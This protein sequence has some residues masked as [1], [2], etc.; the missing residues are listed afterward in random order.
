MYGAQRQ[1]GAIGWGIFALVSG[2]LID[3]FSGA[4]LLKDYTPAFYLVAGLLI[5]DLIV[6]YKWDV[7][8]S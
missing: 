2:F 8:S 7:S 1:Y 3:T 6:S 4:K 5:L